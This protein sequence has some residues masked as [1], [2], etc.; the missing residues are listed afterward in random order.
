MLRLLLSCLL[1]DALPFGWLGACG[2]GQV[3]KCL[4]MA[5]GFCVCVAVL[6]GRPTDWYPYTLV[7]FLPVT[8]FYGMLDGRSWLIILNVFLVIPVLEYACGSEPRNMS[9]EEVRLPMTGVRK[10]ACRLSVVCVCVV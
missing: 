9:K 7:Y 3:A 6:R 1:G 10:A 8:N 5:F 4:G 2:F